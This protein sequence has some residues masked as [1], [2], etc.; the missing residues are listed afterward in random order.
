ME[1]SIRLGPRRDRFIAGILASH[2]AGSKRLVPP[3]L[4]W[5]GLNGVGV[6]GASVLNHLDV[7]EAVIDGVGTR[8]TPG[9]R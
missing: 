5:L 7:V 8:D 9:S 1:G 4:G 6:P 2:G 3:S